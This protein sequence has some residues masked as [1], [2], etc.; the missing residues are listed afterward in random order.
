M[1][2]GTVTRK[3]PR[4]SLTGKLAGR[5]L[6]SGHVVTVTDGRPAASGKVKKIIKESALRHSAAL[7]RLAN[8]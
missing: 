8:K 5:N 6:H 1:D 4:S 7:I 3:V 2:K